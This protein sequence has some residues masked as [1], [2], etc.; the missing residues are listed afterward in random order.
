[1]QTKDV[2]TTRVITVSE[3]AT[4][5]DAARLM[6][7][8]RI[9]GL[10]VVDANGVL[11]GM[12][13][14]GDLLRRTEIATEKSRSRFLAVFLSPGRL[15]DE[16]THAHGRR[17]GEV[18]TPEP[19]SVSE[20]TP[21]E[22][23]VQLIEKKKIRRFPVLRD[24]QLVGIVTRAN[25]VRAYVKAAQYPSEVNV[26]DDQIRGRILS[27]IEKTQWAPTAA[28]EVSVAAGVA[29]LS[30]TIFDDRERAAL[31]VLAEN[32][33]GVRSVCDE[34]VWVEPNSGVVIGPEVAHRPSA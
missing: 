34:L 14:E 29:T 2:M 23:I 21:L 8:R 10:P 13:T 28:L 20:D 6:A 25:L 1:M 31:K 5:L 33:P 9:G 24:G 12:L 7:K 32:V 27:E 17:V 26:S 4:V 3:N 11:V 16:Y 30:G 15:A 19:V 22:K 18:M